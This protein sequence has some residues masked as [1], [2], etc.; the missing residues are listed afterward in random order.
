MTAPNASETR[1]RLH[2]ED[3]GGDG[4]VVVLIHGWPL[5]GASWQAQT[6]ALQNAGYRVIAYDRRGFG[7]SD[8]PATGYDYG[9]LSDDLADL[10]DSRD[11]RDATLVGF[12]MGGGEVARYVA[13]HGTA[14]LAKVVFAAAIPP[15]MMKTADNPDG[16]M[17]PEA[18]AGMEAGLKKDRTAFF[19]Q[20]TRTFFSVDGELKVTEAQ[21]QAAITLCHQSDPNAA[22]QCMHA[23]SETDFR[24]DL[25]KVDV[26]ALILHGD[27]DVIV[28][29]EHSGALTH[30]R[31]PG[32]ELVLLNGAPHGCNVS[33]AQAFNDALLAFLKK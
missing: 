25:N 14:R 30:A 31:I 29:L 19:D 13:R 1:V 15:F 17:T 7:Q 5:S 16:A 22:V 27:A 9:T 4:A 20:F 10:L 11:V 3:S 6:S 8:K 26:P 28:P 33:H 18:E 32:S 24:D 12:S 23:F 21:R 2:V